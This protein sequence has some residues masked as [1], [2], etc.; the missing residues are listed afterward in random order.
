MKKNH[1]CLAS[2]S[3]QII[4]ETRLRYKDRVILAEVSESLDG[5]WDEIRM[6]QLLANLLSN[7]IQYGASDQPII[8][9]VKRDGDDAVIAVTNGG[10]PIPAAYFETIFK[11]F[12]RAPGMDAIEVPSSNLGLGLF[13]SKEIAAAHGGTI[14]VASDKTSG[15]TFS[16]RL[17]SLAT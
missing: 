4:E 16:V 9:N 11:S 7:A 17:P 12:S 13:I 14:A 5:H 2:L 15:T 8:V 6:G 3:N 1:F 10:D